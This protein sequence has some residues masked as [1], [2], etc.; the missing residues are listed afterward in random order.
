D[1][2]ACASIDR[3]PHFSGP[4]L[5]SLVWAAARLKRGQQPSGMFRAFLK[6]WAAHLEP[7]LDGAPSSVS[8]SSTSASPAALDPAPSP[9][10]PEPAPLSDLPDPEA[11]APPLPQEPL[12]LDQLRKALSA[13]TRLAFRPGPSL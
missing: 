12:D 10:G 13:L 9:T 7:F 6:S 8:S 2:L 5:C 4:Q 3:M 1:I 11:T